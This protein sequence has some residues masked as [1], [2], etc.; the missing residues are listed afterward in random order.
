M[1]PSAAARL[2]C[3]CPTGRAL[4]RDERAIA[5]W[6]RKRWPEIKKKPKNKGL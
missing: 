1:A 3:E 2:E 6:K 5:Q 4:E